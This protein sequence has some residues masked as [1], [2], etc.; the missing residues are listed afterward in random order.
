MVECGS[1]R[2][3]KGTKRR[4][5]GKEDQ[6]VVGTKERKEGELRDQGLEMVEEEI[7]SEG[8][9]GRTEEM[10][11]MNEK[12]IGTEIERETTDR[13]IEIGK[14]NRLRDKE[15]SVHAREK[16]MSTENVVEAGHETGMRSRD[17]ANY[18]IN[19]EKNKEKILPTFFAS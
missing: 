19:K 16:G 10:I 4:R 12:A 7:E 5:E 1:V 3:S 8:D 14:E 2:S 6:G 18:H 13:E 9:P 11:G 17:H 15:N